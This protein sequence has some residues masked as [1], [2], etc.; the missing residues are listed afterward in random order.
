MKKHFSNLWKDFIK[1]P[2]IKSGEDFED[3]VADNF[4]PDDLYE[5]LYRTHDVNTNSKRF[6][7]SSMNPDFQFEIRGTN[8]QFW[9]ECKHRENNYDDSII[10]VFKNDQ[11]RRYQSYKNCFLLLCTY[12]FD[13]RYLYFVPMWQIKYNDLYL[14]FLRTYELKLDPPIFPGLVK[15]YLAH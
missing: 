14:S 5:M 15:K 2:S 1:N 8:I 7:R 10:S 4:F 3:D 9:V 11:L 13:D 6:I 12:R